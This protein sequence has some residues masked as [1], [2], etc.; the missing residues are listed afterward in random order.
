MELGQ[1]LMW[2]KCWTW[3]ISD[4]STT[5]VSSFMKHYELSR[6][7]TH[8]I[9]VGMEL[10]WYPQRITV[11]YGV[12]VCVQN[13]VVY[14]GKCKGSAKLDGFGSLWVSTCWHFSETGYCEQN[15]NPPN[16]ATTHNPYP[17]GN[18]SKA[19]TSSFIVQASDRFVSAILSIWTPGLYIHLCQ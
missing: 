4:I 1:C 5:W 6:W 3:K 11:W 17:D 10:F 9:F 14:T 13:R 15:P 8:W 19:L 18:S 12:S 7:I 2:V 16:W